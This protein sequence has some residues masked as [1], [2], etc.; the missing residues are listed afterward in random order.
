MVVGVSICVKATCS[1]LPQAAPHVDTPNEEAKQR[2][3]VE[4]RT[5]YK[6]C[7]IMSGRQFRSPIVNRWS[8]ITDGDGFGAPYTM[9]NFIATYQYRQRGPSSSG[10]PLYSGQSFT[11][12]FPTSQGNASWQD[13]KTPTS[14]FPIACPPGKIGPCLLQPWSRSPRGG[15]P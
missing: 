10:R 13:L 9:L 6:L 14:M 11:P 1:R 4:T 12:I 8:A 5:I 7:E 3:T 2:F 15:G